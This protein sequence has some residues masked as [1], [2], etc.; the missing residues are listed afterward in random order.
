MLIVFVLFFLIHYVTVCTVKNVDNMILE[1]ILP[2]KN[3]QKVQKE[4]ER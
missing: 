1:I 3:H 4:Y 2:V